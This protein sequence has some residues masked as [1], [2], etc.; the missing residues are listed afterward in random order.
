VSGE[1][2][3]ELLAESLDVGGGVLE[4]AERLAMNRAIQR[5]TH[6]PS[7]AV[8]AYALNPASI[9]APN[10]PVVLILSKRAFPQIVSPV[11]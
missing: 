2:A 7:A 3:V 4:S 8:F 10:A 9:I 5:H 1:L 11:V 6:A